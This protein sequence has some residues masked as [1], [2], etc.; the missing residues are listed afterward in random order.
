MSYFPFFIDIA[1]KRCI[2]AGGG[3]VALRKAEKLLS[4]GANIII[5]APEICPELKALPL[6]F[7]EREFQK[8]DLQGAFMAIAAT[9]D[10]ALNHRIYELCTEQ[11]IFINAVDDKANCGFLFPALI[12]EN[13]ITI[14]IS[15]GGTSPVF[16]KFLRM[17]IEN[18]ITESYLQ[19]ADILKRFRPVIRD[20]FCTESQ[21]KEAAEA[22]LD[23]CLIDDI[24]P[25]DIEIYDLLERIAQAHEN[26]NRNESESAGTCTGGT[27][28]NS[29]TE[30]RC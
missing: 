4:F 22:I 26:Q 24:I 25:N 27:C 3:T 29:F 12:H 23:F 20:K 14:G 5:I 18:E 15:T 13:D 2:L 9:N 19:T 28:P 1:G 16:A 7:W 10:S 11:H 30:N 21:R 8:E 6:T 17:M